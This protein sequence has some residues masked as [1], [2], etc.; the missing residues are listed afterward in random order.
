MRMDRIITVRQQTSERDAMNAVKE[1]WTDLFTTRARAYP[2]PGTERSVGDERIAFVP[3]MFE[4]RDES[5]TRSLSPRNRIVM[6]G[7]EYGIQ[8]VLQPERGRNVK[9][10]A[11]AERK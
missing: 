7:V 10:M 11:S 2:A 5:R 4:L 9:V 8:T 6:D 1:V 3:T